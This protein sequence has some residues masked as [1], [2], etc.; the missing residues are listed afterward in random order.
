MSAIRETKFTTTR[1]W[2]SLFAYEKTISGSV[3][4]HARQI[5]ALLLSL[6]LAL[7]WHNSG[8]QQSK[9]SFI[10]FNNKDGLSSSSV[11]AIIKD[12]Y[13]YMWF[14]T[15][16]GL[17]KFDG[18]NFTVY[19][20]S[21]ADTTSLGGNIV[22][23]LCEDRYGNLWVGTNQS[24][25]VYN[26]KKDA[27]LNYNFMGGSATRAICADHLGNLWAGGYYGL[28]K[29][30]YHSDSKKAILISGM[31][32]ERK[33]ANTILS[34]F[35][36]SQRRLWIGSN[37]GLFL[38]RQQG[39]QNYMHADSLP[40]SIA[41]N[42]V[43]SIT[44]DSLKN[45][46]FGTTNGLSRLLN[47]AGSFRSYR[48][49]NTDSHASSDN[50][51]YAV[52]ADESGQL[53]IGTEN[54]I[55]VFDLK[56]EKPVKIQSDK[57]NPYSLV[58]K[59]VRSIYIDD[60]GIYWVGT[61]Q[62]GV[63]KYDGNLAFFN[64]RESNPF[65]PS[66]L[67]SSFVTSFAEAPTG[68]IY[69]GT[70]GGGL[71]LYHKKTG[72]FDHPRLTSEKENNSLVILA[73]ERA[74]NELWV[75]TY[76]HGVYVLNM[77]TGATRQYLKGK[78]SQDI[79]NNDIFCLK[80]DSKGNVWIGTNGNGVIMYEAKTGGLTYPG[81]GTSDSNSLLA[82]S[83][84][85]AIEEDQFG[86]I[87]IGSSGGGVAV[88]NPAS[89]SIKTY[90]TGNTNLP[91]NVVLSLHLDRGGDMWI[92]SLGGGLTMFESKT[93]KFVSY[94]EQHG[95]ANAVIFKILEDNAG[96]LWVSTNKGLSSFDRQTQRFK[97]YTYQN[98]LQR[99]AFYLG[100]GI[101]TSSGEFF[102]GGLDGFNYF[103]P[104]ELHSNK[105]VPSLQFTALKISNKTVVPGDD[106]AITDDISI[107]S[108]IRLDYKQ[109]FSLDFIALDYTAPQDSRY[110]YKLQGFD[111]DWNEVGNSR[112][113]VYTNLDPGEY[114]FRVKASSDDG[115]WTT[116]ERTIRV[117]VRPP[118][119][120]TA[121]AYV[122]YVLLAIGI[123][124]L[125]RYQGMRK[126]RNKFALEQER[127]QVRQMI[128]QER[129]DAEK[130]HAFDQLKIKFLTN[131]SHEFR[132]PISLITGPV[133]RM[134]HEEKDEE[135][136]V[137]LG[138][139]RRNASRLLNLVNQLLDFRKLDENELKLN[140][141]VGDIVAFVR[142]TG[143]SFK[144][145]AETN[146]IKFSYSSS[147][148]E[149]HTLFDRDKI[150][151]ILLNLLSN[152]FKF[153]PGGG[154]VS[155]SIAGGIGSNLKIVV[156]DTGV[157][158]NAEVKEKI[159]DRFYQ[160]NEDG[161]ISNRGSGIGLSIAKE[162]VRLHGGA[163]E[164]E[165]EPGR[166]SAFT[167]LLP[168]ELLSEAYDKTDIY[169]AGTENAKERVPVQQEKN[170]ASS[171]FTVL[172]IED[173]ED[174]R[175][176]LR[177]SL[178]A[179][180]KIVEA[181]DGKEGWQKVLSAHP[182][183]VVSDINMP[184]MD[185]I[186]LSRKIKADKRTS[187]I[188]ILLLTAITGDTNQLKGLETGAS[189]YLTK[190]FNFE[191][192][193]VKIRNLVALNHHLKETYRKQINVIPTEVSVQSEDEKLMTKMLQYIEENIDSPDL[194]V[195]ELSRH[196]YMS[197]GSLYSKIVDLTGET[198]V[199]FIRSI[200]LKKAAAL[201]EK[202]DMKIAQIGYAVG[203]S[204]PNYFARAFRSKF[205]IS[206]SEYAIQKRGFANPEPGA[207][208]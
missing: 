101:K 114:V 57:R 26:R 170:S 89:H 61:Y 14:A 76:R 6:L 93:G 184:G 39:F 198:P 205:N 42:A 145:I 71:N 63:S 137:Q 175:R 200:K 173:N 103:D 158:M 50:S 24:L 121:Y 88:F 147:I 131:L 160:A 174:F 37:A 98:G 108:E 110:S 85:R 31:K 125:L 161:T 124:L 1:E 168:C 185:G 17:N 9:L 84:C 127:L 179:Y 102:F 49:N 140:L 196:L 18:V 15:E 56:S 178:K 146:H 36:D 95:L 47:D 166:G 190:P 104:L 67:S 62:G 7:A 66:G 111:K 116:P 167:V 13:G 107:A 176:Y 163:I 152:A 177:D 77:T 195:E 35:E 156:S 53:W 134:L 43:R 32:M 201:L 180:Y 74:G 82:T 169:E 83:Y 202:S 19:R 120:R 46:W 133:D 91:S 94:S 3:F 149:Y 51:I 25:S 23:S 20:H 117:I 187:H 8:A 78:A 58:G 130:Q 55:D 183:V 44:E 106:E 64:L 162:F 154:S 4:F 90:N 192:L 2:F 151:R 144:E 92:G 41:G 122:L 113:A 21:P 99:S 87:W 186:T 109:N 40:G 206:P 135:K 193:N 171:Q 11:N 172:I 150:E 86:N 126:V 157:G 143:A 207:A 115:S 128:E 45:V 191:I 181:A 29:L 139:V 16:D 118:F 203:F 34:I 65:D 33:L 69:V 142:E 105:N 189:D 182:H 10:N 48:F 138:M 141:T 155:L 28:Y 164:V 70:D 97:N 68:D 52:R 129:K 159:F 12:R 148:S 79:L 165:S 38:Q 27:F 153:T 96:K 119:W 197:R 208:G 204:S 5:K 59:S 73:L 72:L 60:T 132:T 100:A 75:G 194:S 54:G 199:E 30:T 22:S 123:V 136:Q 81:R 188:P 112:T 80:K